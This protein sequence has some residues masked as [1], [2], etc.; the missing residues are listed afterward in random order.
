MSYKPD[1]TLTLL[2]YLTV[3]NAQESLQF[4][5]KA[6]GFRLLGDPVKGEDG[7]IAHV[8]MAH[9]DATIMF[10]PE[11]SWGS[12]NKAPKTSGVP[13]PMGIYLYTPDVDAFYRNAVA[14][15]AQSLGEPQDMFWGDRS[16]RLL[17]CDGY[18][19]SFGTKL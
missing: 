7:Q 6:F 14:N 16:C 2:P 9:E 4:Y 3:Q 1:N 13:C 5:Q 17:D 11:G 15:G 18:V 12:P 10:A 8:E 19:W